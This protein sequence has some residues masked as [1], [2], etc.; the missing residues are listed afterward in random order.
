MTDNLRVSDLD[1]LNIL[2]FDSFKRLK[3]ALFSIAQPGSSSP[4]FEIA[5][6]T[7]DFSSISS[8]DS[9]FSSMF[10]KLRSVSGDDQVKMYYYEELRNLVYRIHEIYVSDTLSIDPEPLK[11]F[12]STFR[13]LKNEL[14]ILS[15][16]LSKL[17]EPK[18]ISC[19]TPKNEETQYQDILNQY[20]FTGSKLCNTKEIHEIRDALNDLCYDPE[21]PSMHAVLIGPSLS[22]KAQV[23]F[24]LAHHMNV[25]Y[26]SFSRLKKMHELFRSISNVFESC[27]GYDLNNVSSKS[28][29]IDPNEPFY[30][31]SLLMFFLKKNLTPKSVEDRFMDY[32]ETN[33]TV[34]RK[35]INTFKSEIISKVLYKI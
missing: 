7:V 33:T 34:Y 23:A 4:S 22:G 17:I 32:I 10:Y 26:L 21:K 16:K 19:F 13:Q 12:N 35:S 18:K 20:I 30:T 14:F 29:Q 24:A 11:R 2:Y 3:K 8:I 28:S 15:E 25:L 27:I 5:S 9:Y 6:I 1:Q 31:V